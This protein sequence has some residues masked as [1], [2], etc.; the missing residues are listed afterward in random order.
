MKK[1]NTFD[2][3]YI[4]KVNENSSGE[5]FFFE[6]EKNKIDKIE[7]LRFITKLPINIHYFTMT[8]EDKV[9]SKLKGLT[10]GYVIK[11]IQSWDEVSK[12]PY[13]IKVIFSDDRMPS[14]LDNSV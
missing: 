11:I 7:I 8:L 1:I 14:H 10:N 2:I 5:T 4:I 9:E 3:C 12:I 6:I 13:Q